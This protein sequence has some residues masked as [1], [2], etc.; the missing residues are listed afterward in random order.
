MRAWRVRA[1]NAAAKAVRERRQGVRFFRFYFHGEKVRLVVDGMPEDYGF[2]TH[3]FVEA[4]DEDSAERAAFE[5][6]RRQ[7]AER[8]AER[9]YLLEVEELAELESFDGISVPG[10]GFTFYPGDQVEQ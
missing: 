4:K 8:G 5:I 6:V 9:G 3:R 2:Y 7:L 10:E 1:S